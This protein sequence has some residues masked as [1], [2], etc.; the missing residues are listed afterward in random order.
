MAS[1][2]AFAATLMVITGALA[3]CGSSD[4]ELRGE[5]ASIGGA[6]QKQQVRVPGQAEAGVAARPESTRSVSETDEWPSCA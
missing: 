2:R 1:S 5:G 3:G 6:V 4:G